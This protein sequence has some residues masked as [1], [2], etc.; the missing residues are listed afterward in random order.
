MSNEN[1]VTG[2]IGLASPEDI[3]DWSSEEICS[4]EE[5][6]N[7][8][9]D[10]ASRVLLGQQNRGWN[11]RNKYRCQCLCGRY[12]SQQFVGKTCEAC[13][14]RVT[15]TWSQ[16]RQMR[17]IEL[18][19]PVVHTWFFKSNPGV[20]GQLLNLD[21]TILD[22]IIYCHRFVVLNPGDTALK[23]GQLLT[24][25][26]TRQ[27]DL[28]G[29]NRS[30]LLATGGEAIGKLL[31]E[32][33]LSA[34]SCQ[35]K[36]EI[37][38]SSSVVHQRQLSER[39][40]LVKSWRD[41]KTSLEWM[42]LNCL[43][44]IPPDHRSRP[45]RKS[46]ILGKS[47]LTELYR[48]I[49]MQN[50]LLKERVD[51]HATEDL[52]LSHK[53]LLQEAVD[54]LLDAD[55][56]PQPHLA[57]SPRS[58]HSTMTAFA[59][60]PRSK[61]SG[62]RVDFSARS[63]A[64]VDPTLELHQCGLPFEIAVKL[65]HPFIV[66]QLVKIGRADSIETAER[67]LDR[68]IR[69]S[70]P[71]KQRSSIAA[72]ELWDILDQV[73]DGRPVLLS[74]PHQCQRAGIQAFEPKFVAGKAIRIHPLVGKCFDIIFEG[75]QLNVHLPLSIE[76]QADA[77]SRMMA[78]NNLFH[79]SNGELVIRPSQDVV[80]GCYYMTLKM[81]QQ[82]EELLTFASTQEV[83][84][85]FLLGKVALH[86]SIEL[87]HSSI[88][89]RWQRREIVEEAEDRVRY[90]DCPWRFETTV[91]RIMFND[92]LP[93]EM[94]F[95][96]LP[97]KAGDLTNI[98]RTFRLTAGNL[99]TT[100]FIDQ[101]KEIA[102]QGLTHSGLSF[103][104][105]DLPTLDSAAR[106]IA[107]AEKDVLCQER[108]FDRDMSSKLEL[109]N[110]KRNIWSDRSH[111]ILTRVMEDYR[112][113]RSDDRA[114][115]NPVYSM[116]E[117]D[118]LGGRL[119]IGQL[120]GIQGLTHK[121]NG[122]L[123]EVPI[124]SNFR[125]GLS[126]LEYFMSS[127]RNRRDEAV[128]V[129]KTKQSWDLTKK[130]A[131]A[132]ENIVVTM[133]DCG[134]TNGVD[135]GR[136]DIGEKVD[137]S[138]ANAVR[139][140]VSRQEIVSPITDEVLVRKDEMITND[141]ARQIEEMGLEAIPIRSPMTCEAKA[142]VC[143]LCYGMDPSTG[144]LVEEGVAVGI[145]AA[146]SL[147]EPG[148]L[149]EERTFNM[150]CPSTHNDE[151]EITSTRGGHV[152]LSRIQAMRND[153]GHWIVVRQF[154]EIQILDIRDRI[155]ENFRVPLGARLY[156]HEGESVGA[157]QV[158]STC[159]PN[160]VPTV[161]EVDGTIHFEDLAEGH[162]LRTDVD[163]FGN[164]RRTVT[165]QN[166]G[167]HPQIVLNDS[168]G[169]LLEWYDL[170]E[171]TILDVTEGQQVT[172][173]T[174]IARTK[175]RRGSSA[176]WEFDVG[177]PELIAT[178]EAKSPQSPAILV[179]ESGEVQDIFVDDGGESIVVIRSDDGTL[180]E[181]R[182][183]LG[184]FPPYHPQDRVEAGEPLVDG[185]K[186]PHDILR[187]FGNQAVQQHLLEAIRRNYSAHRVNV[188]LKHI[189][190]VVS[191]MLRLVKIDD[192]GDT[193][194]LSGA[195]VDR[196]A[197]QSA[198]QELTS[199]VRAIDPGDSDFRTGD[200]LS[201]ATMHEWNQLLADLRGNLMKTAEL[202]PATSSPMLL[203]LTE[204]AN[205]IDSALVRATVGG[206][207]KVLT[208]TVI[209][210]EADSR[211]GLKESRILGR[212]M[213]A[214]TGFP[215]IRDSERND[216]H[217]GSDEADHKPTPDQLYA[218]AE[219]LI[220]DAR[221]RE[222]TVRKVDGPECSFSDIAQPYV[223]IEYDGSKEILRDALGELFE[224]TR[225]CLVSDMLNI[226]RVI[227][228][229]PPSLG[230][231]SQLEFLSLGVNFYRYSADDLVYYELESPG[232][233]GTDLSPLSTL[234]S[235]TRLDLEGC[236]A[237]SD[238]SPLSHLKSLQILN[239]SGCPMIS[240]LLPLSSLP[241]LQSLDL[242]RCWEI[243]DLAPLGQLTSL[244]TLF[245]YARDLT[246]YLFPLAALTSLQ[247]LDLQRL[248]FVNDLRP[249]RHMTSLHELTLSG[250]A[251]PDLSPLTALTELRSL[252]L[253]FDRIKD[254]SI[255]KSLN[256]LES[257]ELTNCHRLSDLTL[258]SSL[259]TLKSLVLRGCECIT[260]LAPVGNL[261]SLESLTLRDLEHV[262]F[263]P[264]RTLLGSL[265]ELTI[266]NS[267]FTDV[268]TQLNGEYYH[269]AI[270]RVRKHFLES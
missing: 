131:D 104:C 73:I 54:G 45:P 160:W 93:P 133:R 260:D 137:L 66:R 191:Q 242:R 158:L 215:G 214:G 255:L 65:F 266:H 80:I 142:G 135:R 9:S 116:N 100:R 210:V 36:A 233:Q 224:Y 91:G 55:R 262:S 228:R 230:E 42:V 175:Q 219:L 231:L 184:F 134:T 13:G 168:A 61:R 41:R 235:L 185:I 1:V 174:V 249:L 212:L 39:L 268:G 244:R 11:W 151:R 123:Y 72:D 176:V 76:A 128:K 153:E 251:R 34:L 141:I 232:F 136:I 125:E 234:S 5:F 2:K 95:Y 94:P 118:A 97:L 241:A 186:C 188:D 119:P 198:N 25:D 117:S 86:S 166:R 70:W 154:G 238:L 79:P 78:Q 49:L 236:P 258:L 124:K 162:S 143:Q 64:V 132:C 23:T 190:I 108:Y 14:M 209:A 150:R 106:F 187:I 10:L 211:L 15:R 89:L 226:N 87:R 67:M 182:L 192:P 48:E 43:P 96:N 180:N 252:T 183:P 57:T 267:D 145:I 259:T 222:S 20:V 254:I 6:D 148:K 92:I 50:L 152:R 227:D 114:Y 157:G 130:L 18:V 193:N 223:V 263:A 107:D 31:A 53:R 63:V 270:E 85:A 12:Q 155:L 147:G 113:D 225:G 98:I 189:E 3:R 178:F 203:G 69:S 40:N 127:Q 21:P 24:W 138:L 229:L 75:E 17:H 144:S 213:P 246:D 46:S 173:G 84:T 115:V 88:D 35:L 200:L 60:T 82:P 217:P 237:I 257:L 27:L 8:K 77:K 56:V 122:D 81:P 59:H 202:Q 220:E 99:A 52:I 196:V 16:P 112:L 177:F 156:V 248:G 243:R 171:Q 111:Q 139:G 216:V 146:Q 30:S 170:N 163:P 221:G 250:K 121:P 71:F 109:Y 129:S 181:Y 201:R 159:D 204:L 239:L 164:L 37:T 205:H 149:L 90:N 161:C 207:M 140:C 247:T 240:D 256:G 126:A 165:K 269:N 47:D 38:Q 44:V 195:L 105:S 68:P 28:K 169:T 245:L 110:Q 167:L 51:G 265:G 29:V 58:R 32:V 199:N 83:H 74:R 19:V 206:A 22:Q 4:L 120:A 264:I 103:A 26:E 253:S 261:T 102:L 101:I 62:S 208:S 197:F 33:N 194:L 172:K 218:S 7:W 179:A